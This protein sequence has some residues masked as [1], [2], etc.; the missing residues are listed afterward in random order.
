VSGSVVSATCSDGVVTTTS[1]GGRWKRT[2]RSW[3]IRARSG[4]EGTTDIF[5]SRAAFDPFL[6]VGLDDGENT[7]RTMASAVTANYFQTFGVRLAPGRPFTLADL[8]VLDSN[9]LDDIAT[10]WTSG[11]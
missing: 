11:S 5:E 3:A 4:R 10:R 6:S 8:V 9:P 7:R 2:V 1:F